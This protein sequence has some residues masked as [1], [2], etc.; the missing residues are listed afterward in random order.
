VTEPL[1]Y[2]EANAA[3]RLVRRFSSSGPGSWLFVRVAH[4][5][6]RPVYRLTRGRRTFASLV[7]GI[8]V[9]MLTTTGAKSGKSRTV[10]VLGMPTPDGIA[11]IASNFGQERHP[12]WR[13]NL[14]ANPEGEV[15]VIDG[16]SYGFRAVE[17]E[18]E[19]RERIW[20]QALRVYPGFTQYARRASH[21]DIAVFVLERR[22][23]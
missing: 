3:Q 14:R 15:A 12:A 2:A 22:D 18:G 20:D 10:P 5:I 6:D 7:S 19:R 9:A 23:S 21:R 11:V 17:V 16:P 8:P 13:H 1:G 4:R